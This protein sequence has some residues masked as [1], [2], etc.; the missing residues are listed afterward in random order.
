M[1]ESFTPPSIVVGIDGSRGAVRAALWAIDEAISRDIPLRLV[2]AI[3]PPG[4]DPAN[5]QEEARLL[6]GAEFAVRSAA[7]AVEATG[8]QVK[9]EVEI[10]QGL[11][12][13]T[14]VDASRVAAMICVG[15]VGL[16][17]FDADR[18]GSTAT[19]LVTAAHCPVTIVRGEDR[20]AGHDPGWI[21]VEL[22]E[23]PDSAAVLQFGV[24][25][26]R[27]RGAPLRVL[28]SWQSRYTDVHDSHAV[29]DGNRMVRA[30]LDRRLSHWKNQYPDLDA[31]PVAIHGSV[32]NY[33]AKH[34][35]SIQLV[36][37]GARNARGIEELLGPTGSAALHNTDC[38]VL[39]VDRQR[40]L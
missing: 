1:P 21:V 29:S 12:I 18:I 40:L 15:E 10:L 4:P 20:I 39:V 34:A 2:Y 3:H 17:H 13:A 36:V 6:A 32:L 5:P 37:V 22:D 30:Q 14:L 19:A 38:S 28:G 26:A 35:G 11:P 31:R 7:D 33:L 9:L 16:K 25:E 23:S 27:L 24:A 8:R